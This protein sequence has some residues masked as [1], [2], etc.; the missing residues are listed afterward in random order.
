MVSD[1][2][3][4]IKK[5]NCRGKKILRMTKIALIGEG[6][7]EWTYSIIST[8]RYDFEF[9]K[10]LKVNKICWSINPLI[11]YYEDVKETLDSMRS[12]MQSKRTA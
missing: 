4:A 11:K 12:Y 6:N 8:N 5:W 1:I 3:E 10:H 2:Y 7:P 9:L